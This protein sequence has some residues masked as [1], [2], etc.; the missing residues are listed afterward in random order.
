MKAW[1][2]MVLLIALLQGCATQLAPRPGFAPQDADAAPEAVELRFQHSFIA[3]TGDAA[4]MAPE[5]LQ[6]GD[7]L[8]TSMSSLRS[9]AIRLMTFAPVSHV[10]VYIGDRQVVEAVGSGVRVRGIDELLGEETVV[11]AFPPP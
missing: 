11:L 9:A 8:L 6:P 1:T 4:V 5:E 3:P 2:S 10:A 7:I